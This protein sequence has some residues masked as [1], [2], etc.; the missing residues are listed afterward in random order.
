MTSTTSTTVKVDWDEIPCV[1]R[2]GKLVEYNITMKDSIGSVILS[3][4]ITESRYDFL[5][6][7]P[8]SSHEITV[9]FSNSVGS[10]APANISVR[11]EQAGNMHIYVTGVCRCRCL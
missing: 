4:T 8:F 3:D 2:N 7:L 5:G 6:L 10:S 11:T 1:L 9:I